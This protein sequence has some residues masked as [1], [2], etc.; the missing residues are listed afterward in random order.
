MAALCGRNPGDLA[1]GTP[2]HPIGAD[3]AWA[4]HRDSAWLRASECLRHRGWMA[5]LHV[6]P[7]P[8]P[9][10]VHRDYVHMLAIDLARGS[11]KRLEQSANLTAARG[12]QGAPNAAG[13]A[14]CGSS[15]VLSSG[16]CARRPSEPTA[17][18]SL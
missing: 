1:I 2:L 5:R 6:F 12:L 7:V 11:G 4:S 10:T 8:I 9:G 13:S 16:P 14:R 18:S 15:I 17:G 3:I